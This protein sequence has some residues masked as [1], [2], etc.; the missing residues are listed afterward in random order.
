MQTTIHRL[1]TSAAFATLRLSA[2]EHAQVEEALACKGRLLFDNIEVFARGNGWYAL[3]PRDEEI[4][5]LQDFGVVITHTRVLRQAL[6]LVR[7]I[8]LPAQTAKTVNRSHARRLPVRY[9]GKHHRPVV[10]DRAV[11]AS[12]GLSTELYCK[13][14]A[15]P[16]LSETT[17][18]AVPSRES[19]LALAH[20]FNIQGAN[21]CR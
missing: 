2:K 6:G 9:L 4:T 12:D 10:V 5:T 17:V 8:L 13:L 20:R 19:L 21:P 18:Q 15:R 16:Q 11:Q 7:K 14:C 1:G 3:Y